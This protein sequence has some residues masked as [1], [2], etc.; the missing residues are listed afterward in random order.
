[1]NKLTMR[2]EGQRR[3]KMR[4]MRAGCRGMSWEKGGRDLDVEGRTGLRMNDDW[5]SENWVLYFLAFIIF[6]W[7]KMKDCLLLSF[8]SVSRRKLSPFGRKPDVVIIL[9][10]FSLSRELS[11]IWST[12]ARDHRSVIT[13]RDDSYESESRNHGDDALPAVVHVIFGLVATELG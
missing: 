9:F 2:D 5:R 1:M 6:L 11:F 12:A 8:L 13:S 10:G 7:E 3:W 4:G